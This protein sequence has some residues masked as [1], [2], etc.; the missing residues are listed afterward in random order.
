MYVNRY[1]V[2]EF[3]SN[4][5]QF[6]I[7]G[8]VVSG[9]GESRFVFEDFSYIEKIR[10]EVLIKNLEIEFYIGDE[11][12]HE[13]SADYNEKT[14][15]DVAVRTIIEDFSTDV[16]YNWK[17][18]FSKKNIKVTYLNVNDTYKHYTV[19]LNF[20]FSKNEN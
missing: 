4:H 10:T 6:N 15:L 3:K 12:V 16:I 8:Y 2:Y 1:E 7:E 18:V 19:D 20:D 14:S 17:S 11:L 13:I 9:R 5:E